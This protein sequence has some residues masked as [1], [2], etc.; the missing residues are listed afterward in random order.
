LCVPRPREYRA[1]RHCVS[2]ALT[3]LCCCVPSPRLP[4]PPLFPC[5]LGVGGVSCYVAGALRRQAP[6]EVSVGLAQEVG[7]FPSLDY[8]LTITCL[9][10][11]HCPL[12]LCEGT[13]F[14][15]NFPQPARSSRIVAS[16]VVSFL[17]I[18][19]QSD[20]PFCCLTGTPRPCSAGLQTGEVCHPTPM[21][22]LSADQLPIRR[23][24]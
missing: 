13:L 6:W 18:S 21:C 11:S 24:V 4:P 20:L 14:L 16:V 5:G 15:P 22:A 7:D 9:T 1:L 8:S 23:R 10:A 2:V 12:Q 19:S 3:L 17:V